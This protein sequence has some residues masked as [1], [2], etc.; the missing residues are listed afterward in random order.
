M[1]WTR[2]SIEPM[3][4]EIER[5]SLLQCAPGLLATHAQI[6]FDGLILHTK[7]VPG[8]WQGSHFQVVQH[9]TRQ[10]RNC[11][12]LTA[13]CTLLRHGFDRCHSH[14][15]KTTHNAQTHNLLSIDSVTKNCPICGQL[16]RTGFAIL[17][18]SEVHGALTAPDS[19]V[20]VWC[21]INCYLLTY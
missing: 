14:A 10:V 9:V 1:S 5:E 11:S 2:I 13:E 7:L 21:Y 6:H 17:A 12:V 8:T 3:E 15:R 16:F 4:Q 19:P 18:N 20:R